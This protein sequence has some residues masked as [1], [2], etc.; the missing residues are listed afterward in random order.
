MAL[1]VHKFGGTSVGSIERIQA[2]A[3]RVAATRAQGHDLVVVVSAMGHETDRLVDLAQALVPPPPVDDLAYRRELD[4]LLS[5]GEQV[6]IALVAMALQ[7]V[8]CMALSLTGAQAGILTERE[9]GAARIIEISSDR[10]QRYLAQGHVVIVAGFQGIASPVDLDITTL[11]R[12]GSDTTAVALAVALQAERCDIFTDVPGV[13]TTDPRLVPEARLIPAITSEEMLELASLGAQVLHPRAVELARNFG[14]KLQVRSSWTEEPG[15][16]VLSSGSRRRSG[17]TALAGLEMTQAI[18]A[19]TVNREQAKVVLL[20]VPDQPGIAAQLFEAIATAGINV[21]LI[22]QSIHTS[23]GRPSNDIAFTVERAQAQ[24]A[25][26]V[27]ETVGRALGCR[28]VLVDAHVAKVSIA[29]AGMIGRPSVAAEMFE[30]LAAAGINI[31]MISMSEIKVSCL[32]DLAYASDAALQLSQYFQVV[33]RALERHGSE[34]GLQS[35]PV[36]GVALDRKQARLA[37]LQV[38][39]R[40]GYAAKIF[41]RLAAANIAIDTIIQSQRHLTNAQGEATNDIAFTTALGQVRTAAMV[42]RQVALELGCGAVIVDEQIAKVSIVG[43]DMEAHP[44]TAAALF[45]ALA[46]A[47]VNIEMISTSEIKVSCVVSD[48]AAINALQTAHTAFQLGL[49]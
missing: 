4:M 11:G 32:I 1:L 10:I 19:V 16:L 31:Q 13:F 14:L 40:P 7:Q 36:R 44:G 45:R 29:G 41:R 17:R 38:P 46:S 37:V 26:T 20:H 22:L 5:T 33:P 48:A 8:G 42:L 28:E 35:A 2:V 18:D 39:D 12:G 24:A 3:Q 34:L 9:H 21:D 6:S 49:A 15:T 23:D 43:A 47:G 25:A 27:A 30:V